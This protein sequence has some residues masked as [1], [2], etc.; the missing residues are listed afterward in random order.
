MIAEVFIVGLGQIGMGYDLHLDP[1]SHV[2][3]HARAFSQHPKYRLIGGV[4]QA[5]DRRK[6][7]EL[8]YGCPA[9]DDVDVALSHHQPDLVIIAVPTRFHAGIL[10]RVLERSH[11]KMILCEKPLSYDLAEARSMVQAC[12]KGGVPL[13]VNYMRRSNVGVIE[14]K[15][16]MTFGEF[17]V[18]IKGV[19]WYSKG[20]LHNGS[21]FFNLLEYWLGPM[22]KSMVLNCGRILDETDSEPD[23]QVTFE[24]GNVVFLAA[25]EEEFSHCTIEL[26]SPNGRLRYERGGELIQWQSTQPAT[27]AHGY[28][29]LSDR[30]EIINSDMNRYQWYVAEELAKILGG[31]DAQLCSGGDA[32]HTL[33]SMKH[34]L[35]RTGI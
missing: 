19:C 9:Y 30:P 11:P 12:A 8:T 24:C 1:A 35:E 17:G 21:H 13:Y 5:K 7:F 14:I 22:K 23:V 4:E 32:L 27:Q 15:R 26:L 2:C 20:F 25:R 6:A 28:T 33:E 3:T 10:Q 34:A 31:Q 18:P 16:R 29:V